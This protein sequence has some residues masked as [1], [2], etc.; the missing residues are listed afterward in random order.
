MKKKF[1]FF[2]LTL[3]VVISGI[4]LVGCDM[5]TGEPEIPDYNADI[6]AAGFR[7]NHDRRRTDH[8]GLLPSDR[9]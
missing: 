8:R 3:L 4:S 7:E 5:G 6:Q 1:L 2:V 9:R